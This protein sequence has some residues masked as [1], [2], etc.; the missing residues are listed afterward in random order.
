MTDATFWFDFAS[1]NA[2]LVHRVIPGIEA[3]TGARFHLC[4]DPRQ[5]RL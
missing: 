1:P 5:T 3:R 2:Y 4:R